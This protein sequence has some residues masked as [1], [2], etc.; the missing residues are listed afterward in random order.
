[1]CSSSEAPAATCLPC[2]ASPFLGTNLNHL[3]LAELEIALQQWKRKRTQESKQH[4][5]QQSDADIL[6]AN[7]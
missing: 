5:P 4:H 1:M 7:W 6:I 2:E 3:I